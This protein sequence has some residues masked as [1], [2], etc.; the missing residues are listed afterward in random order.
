M[1]HDCNLAINS[2]LLTKLVKFLLAEL[3][4]HSNIISSPCKYACAIILTATNYFAE[5]INNYC[6]LEFNLDMEI[7]MLMVCGNRQ[8]NDA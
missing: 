6:N 2:S 1:W 7:L 5:I 4:T 3:Y 8:L